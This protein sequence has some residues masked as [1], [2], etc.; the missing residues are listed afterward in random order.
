MCLSNRD[1]EA[2]NVEK[3]D[4]QKL[5]SVRKRRGCSRSA[6]AFRR[7]IATSMEFSI[8]PGV[9]TEHCSAADNR[10]DVFLQAQ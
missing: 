2:Q 3:S 8:I 6:E 10:L 7:E 4:A 5:A 1:K 9:E